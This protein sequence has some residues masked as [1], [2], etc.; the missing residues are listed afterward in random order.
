M[1]HIDQIKISIDDLQKAP[2]GSAAFQDVVRRKIRKAD[3]FR[4]TKRSFDFRN[5][6]E[7]Y[8]VLSADIYAQ[9]ETIPPRPTQEE[10]WNPLLPIAKPMT[11]RP[12][13][14][15]TGPAGLFCALYLAKAGLSPIVF[16]RGHDAETRTKDVQHFWNGGS[17]NPNSN[18]QFGEGGAGTF[19]D[20]KLTTLVKEKNGLGR[21]V[22]ETF[23]AHG[24]PE[25]IR[26]ASKP[27]IGTDLLRE[28]V[29]NLRKE[30]IRLGGEVHFNTT[31]TE[32]LHQN[33]QIYGV[34]AGDR[35]FESTKVFLCVGHSA[36]DTFEMLARK[37]VQMEQKPFSMG[38]RIQHPQDLINRAQYGPHGDLLGTRYP[39]DYKLSYHTASGRGVYTFCMC[40]GGYVV[41]AASEEGGIVT[42]GMSNYD[43]ASGVANS[44]VLVSVTPGDFV[45]Y[46]SDVLA[47][48]R[49]QRHFEQQAFLVGGKDYALPCQTVGDFLSGKK[50]P[51]PYEVAIKGQTKMADLTTILPNYIVE[52]LREGLPALDYKL[53]GFADPRATFTGIE[54]RTSSPIRILRDSQ[55]GESNIAGLFPVGE[56]AGYAG[57]I[58]SSAIDG[59]RIAALACKAPL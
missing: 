29:V 36:R 31:V 39:A 43:R 40:P 33:G 11:D 5:K 49:M 59:I 55:T 3:K 1:R 22:T 35:I 13:V 52:A 46:G 2:E 50:A 27:H 38:L 4:I 21:L 16:E 8:M 7:P 53:K 10:L 51:L 24:A 15:G 57:G 48:M 54:S 34:Q 32:I 18:V 9:N 25:D 58:M 41:N 17:L 37:G 19:S 47:G 44:A 20:G 30:I 45:P 12:I 56:G 23:I 42:N 6:Q 14:I 28:V 26:I